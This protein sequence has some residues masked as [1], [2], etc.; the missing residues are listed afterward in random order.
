MRLTLLLNFPNK[1][2][3]ECGQF[4][5]IKINCKLNSA[6]CPQKSPPFRDYLKNAKNRELSN[7]DFNGFIW[8]VVLD[9]NQ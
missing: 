5:K 6:N 8:W 1:G 3:E 9:L 4:R 7:P 2:E